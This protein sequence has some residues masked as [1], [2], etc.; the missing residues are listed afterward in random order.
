MYFIFIPFDC[1]WN[2]WCR[3]CRNHPPHGR[4]HCRLPHARSDD[5]AISFYQ[6]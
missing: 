2:R 4:E 3:R 5:Q 6:L 1:T